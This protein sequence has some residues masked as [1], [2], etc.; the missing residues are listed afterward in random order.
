MVASPSPSRRTRELSERQRQVLPLLTQ[1][2]WAREIGAR[3]GLAEPTVRN[4]IRAILSKLGCHSQLEA[5]AVAARRGLLDDGDPHGRARA[6][7]HEESPV[8]AGL[9]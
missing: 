6:G 8:E 4:H 1:G 9:S 7:V 2:V 3:L 5:V